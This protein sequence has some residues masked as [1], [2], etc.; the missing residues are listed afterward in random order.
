MLFDNRYLMFDSLLKRPLGAEGA[1]K[2]HSW[3]VSGC[4]SSLYSSKRSFVGVETEERGVCV[5]L[6]FVSSQD[7]DAV[8][9]PADGAG[10]AAFGEGFSVR[11][12]IQRDII[13]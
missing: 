9:V 11:K 10:V 1:S 2:N 5:F 13:Y 6:F 7:P 12:L 3:S 8:V 4:F